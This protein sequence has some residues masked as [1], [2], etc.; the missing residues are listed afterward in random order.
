MALSSAWRLFGAARSPAPSTRAVGE[1]RSRPESTCAIAVDR[2]GNACCTVR[3]IEAPGR[4]AM[5]PIALY[6]RAP[7]TP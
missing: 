2:V 4:A 5:P 6:R 3:D 1:R 7:P